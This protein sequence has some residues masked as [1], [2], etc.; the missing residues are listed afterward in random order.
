MTYAESSV[1]K[2]S[3]PWRAATVPWSTGNA[4]ASS[5]AIQITS[6][7]RWLQ[8]NRIKYMSNKDGYLVTT[9]DAI[10]RALECQSK[11]GG[12]TFDGPDFSSLASRRSKT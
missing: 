11:K 10:N 7:M 9:I 8:M 12:R 1:R 2:S 5:P 6:V 4:C 3:A